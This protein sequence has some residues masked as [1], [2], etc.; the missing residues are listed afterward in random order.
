ME[1]GELFSVLWNKK[2]DFEYIKGGRVRVT[3]QCPAKVKLFRVEMDAIVPVQNIYNPGTCSV[4]LATCTADLTEI[5]AVVIGPQERLSVFLPDDKANYIVVSCLAE[6]RCQGIGILE[7][8]D[9]P[10]V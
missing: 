6:P 2:T 1:N 8:D 3:L 5:N 4:V 7:C 10:R 9:I